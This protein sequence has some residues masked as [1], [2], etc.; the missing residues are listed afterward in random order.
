MSRVHD[1]LRKA[2]KEK[3]TETAP[4]RQTTPFFVGVWPFFA[5]SG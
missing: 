5:E 2:A 3:A 1:A 4:A